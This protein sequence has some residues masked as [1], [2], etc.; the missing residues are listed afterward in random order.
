MSI[1]GR[2][3][4]RRYF[5]V[6]P[7]RP[8][9][10][11][12]VAFVFIW[13]SVSYRV[14]VF[15]EGSPLLIIVKGAA[16]SAITG[17]VMGLCLAVVSRLRGPQ[18]ANIVE[19]VFVALLV[20]FIANSTRVLLGQVPGVEGQSMVGVVITGSGRLALVIVLVQAIAGAA[21]WRLQG[22]IDRA[23]KALEDSR[24][25]QEMMLEAD[26]A[27]RRQVSEMLHDDVQAGLVAACLELRMASSGMS[28]E[29]REPVLSVIN[30]LENMRSLDVRAAA[31]VLSPNLDSQDLDHALV[32]LGSRYSPGMT[33]GIH[34]DR[35]LQERLLHDSPDVLLASYRIVE[36]GILNSAVHGS[37][38]RC[39]VRISED[40]GRV[41]V[42]V[43]DNGRGVSTTTPGLGSALITTWTRVLDGEWSLTSDEN[44][45]SLE[46]WLTP[47]V[48]PEEGSSAGH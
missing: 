48:T 7:Y 36:Q 15:S 35:Q 39:E 47:N 25:Q 6:W 11:G 16:I 9:L 34:V 21:S 2:L 10:V 18:A 33:V 40:D 46:A 20:G 29:E 1:D 43:T 27:V 8:T 12:V 24:Q 14:P 37:A 30:R 44:G 31:R 28:D 26:E 19:Y 3:P 4:L 22:Q 17:L 23:E 32:E 42:R 38:T 45:T 13:G 41:R 5:G